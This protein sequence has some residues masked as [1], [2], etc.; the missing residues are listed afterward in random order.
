MKF[1]VR[2]I[3]DVIFRAKKEM[4]FGS[5]TVKEDQ[6]VLYFDS[7]KTSTLEGAATTVYATG[8]KGNARLIAWE[9]SMNVC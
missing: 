9:G 3:C 4:K 7:L 2:E 6:P 5:T 1:G 8:G